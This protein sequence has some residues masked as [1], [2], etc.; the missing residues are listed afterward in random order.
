M[1]AGGCVTGASPARGLLSPLFDP[2]GPHVRP[3][4]VERQFDP[5]DVAFVP[6]AFA[7]THVNLTHRNWTAVGQPDVAWLPVVDPRGPLTP[8]FDGWSLDAWLLPADGEPLLPSRAGEAEQRLSLEEGPVVETR[9][10][11]DGCS[12]ESLADVVWQD[13]Q[14]AAARGR[15]G[16]RRRPALGRRNRPGRPPRAGRGGPRHRRVV[17]AGPLCPPR[18]RPLR[19]GRGRQRPPERGGERLDADLAL[20]RDRVGPVEHA[21]R[22]G[23]ESHRHRPGPVRGAGSCLA[24][25]SPEAGE[26]GARAPPA[27]P[28]CLVPKQPTFCRRTDFNPFAVGRT[29]G[30]D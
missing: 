6:R 18:P 10:G 8:L 15:D 26:R 17:R 7:I 20:P 9:V 21:R 28:G 19:P 13:G 22:G 23:G 12:L 5:H 2:P 24:P 1:G 27:L 11:R 14:P 29:D 3:W 30:T 25:L 4:W 16:L